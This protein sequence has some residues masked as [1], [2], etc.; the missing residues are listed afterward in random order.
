M[1]LWMGRRAFS[2]QWLVIKIENGRISWIWL[3]S[4]SILFKRRK[5]NWNNDEFESRE[6]W[7]NWIGKMLLLF[8]IVSFFFF[9][10]FVWYNATCNVKFQ[11]FHE[12]GN[13]ESRVT[14]PTAPSGYRVTYLAI[15]Y[16]W[17]MCSTTLKFLP[18]GHYA[19]DFT[20]L[21]V[22][23]V[24]LRSY[25]DFLTSPDFQLMRRILLVL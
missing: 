16:Q 5:I 6:K 2:G 8:L 24:Q 12:I 15:F 1:K 10:I 23:N 11:R 25:I 18:R 9:F 21:F 19:N 7:L 14:C 22:I 3:T 4:E 20:T 13:S 17:I